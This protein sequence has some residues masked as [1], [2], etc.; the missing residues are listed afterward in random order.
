MIEIARQEILGITP[1]IFEAFTA[2]E[3]S[4]EDKITF[5]QWLIVIL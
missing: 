5:N 3:I 1:M 4:D 2:E